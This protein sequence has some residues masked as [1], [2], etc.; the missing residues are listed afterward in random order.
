MARFEREKAHVMPLCGQP[1]FQLAARVSRIVAED[2]LVSF[3]ANR[4][5]VPFSLV[6]KTVEVQ[7][8][9]E[10]V[11]L[12]HRDQ[13]VARHQLLA[14]KHR[15]AILPEHSPGAIVRN[16][17]SRRSATLTHRLHPGVQPEVEIRDLEIYEQLGGHFATEEAAQ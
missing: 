10:E 14:G 1:G 15:L 9:G 12:F 6:G 4:Y 3:Q 11:H 16:T 8:Q 2:W 5:W 13:L 17:R 7:R